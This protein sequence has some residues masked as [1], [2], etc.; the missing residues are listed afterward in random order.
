MGFYILLPPDK[1][2]ENIVPFDSN[3]STDIPFDPEK[4]IKTIFKSYDSESLQNPDNYFENPKNYCLICDCGIY[5][6]KDP[7]SRFLEI[8]SAKLF[9][10]NGILKCKTCKEIIGYIPREL[11]S[12]KDI[13]IQR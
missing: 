5:S 9:L 3:K 6:P 4:S 10:D 8:S 2:P 1:N 11:T 7:L 13:N 12:F